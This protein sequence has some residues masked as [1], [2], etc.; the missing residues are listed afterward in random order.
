[1]ENKKEETHVPKGMNTVQVIIF[2]CL[3]VGGF[4]LIISS[5]L[6]NPES[7]PPIPLSQ[8]P[9]KNNPTFSEISQTDQARLREIFTG[10]MQNT[11]PVT[12]DLKNEVKTIFKKYNATDAEQTDFIFYG[13]YFVANYQG[14]FYT[15][16]L[17]A[18]SSGVPVK[19]DDRLNLE[20]EALSRGLI[21]AER[22][23]LNDEEMNLIANHQ[24]VV[25]SDGKQI[26]FT[27]DIIKST[28]K[29]IGLV[30]DRII[31]LLK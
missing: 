23:K 2:I 16:A 3:I 7:P 4:I 6:N 22:I 31:S 24:A 26:V 25:G 5:K 15:D 30:T 27:A 20:K 21:T 10:V 14:L 9:V 18:V 19:S 28:M 11:I 17:R 29:N 8:L 1:M 13:P 12:P